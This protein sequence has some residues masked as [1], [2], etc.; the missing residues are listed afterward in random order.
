MKTGHTDP[1][2]NESLRH[3]K[4]IISNRISDTAEKDMILRWHMLLHLASRLEENRNDANRML[5]DLNKKPSPLLHNADLTE[6]TQYPLENLRGIDSEFFINDTNIKMLLKA[7]HGLFNS[8]IDNDDMLLTIDR[9]I[10]DHLSDEW[11]ILNNN[12]KNP[13]IISFKSPVFKR[14]DIKSTEITIGN[15]IQDIITSEITPEDKTA[16]IKEQTS[17]F[18][19]MFQTESEDSQILFS[20][21]LFQSAENSEE[22]I[23]DPVLKFLSGRALIFAEKNG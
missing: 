23:D 4:S 15:Y 3:I 12:L 10:F 16:A 21:L 8:L 18:E 19:S 9:R 17:E 6:N 14:A 1:T 13:G 2:S 11:D 7:W 22:V 20:L 5:E